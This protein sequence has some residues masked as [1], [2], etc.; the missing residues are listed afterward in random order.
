MT[1]QNAVPT[2]LQLTVMDPVFRDRPN[3]RLDALRAVA[4]GADGRL[5][6]DEAAAFV[7]KFVTRRLERLAA[8]VAEVAE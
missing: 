3:E 1:D 4:V 2:G 6:R 5:S 8:K 7:D